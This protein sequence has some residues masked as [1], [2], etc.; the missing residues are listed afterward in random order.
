MYPLL[1][2]LSA[3]PCESLQLQ[4]HPSHC[5]RPTQPCTLLMEMKFVP[6]C[7]VPILNIFSLIILF[8]HLQ[9]A[10]QTLTLPTPK[11]PRLPTSTSMSPTPVPQDSIPHASLTLYNPNGSTTLLNIT[12]LILTSGETLNFTDGIGRLGSTAAVNY[13]AKQDKDAS[14][15]VFVGLIGAVGLILLAGWAWRGIDGWMGRKR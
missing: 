10:H 8:P 6:Q 1:C 11:P 3:N 15:L 13:W 2:L 7:L 12:S 9:T 14:F 4:P 5:E